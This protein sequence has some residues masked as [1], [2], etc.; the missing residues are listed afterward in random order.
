MIT[1]RID[2]YSWTE[3]WLVEA[4]NSAMNDLV[5]SKTRPRVLFSGLFSVAY[6]YLRDIADMTD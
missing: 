5:T 3:K 1:V 6:P 2:V 4:V